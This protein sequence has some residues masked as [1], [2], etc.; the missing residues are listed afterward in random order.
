MAQAA[1][2]QTEKA[3]TENIRARGA[4][5]LEGGGG[6]GAALQTKTDVANMD[7]KELDALISRVMR[8][9]KIT[10]T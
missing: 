9:E 10:L 4:R 1:K 6:A 5:P 7:K 2:Q 8:G 3:V